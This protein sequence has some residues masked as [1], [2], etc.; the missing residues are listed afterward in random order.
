MYK[1]LREHRLYS[2]HSLK[3]LGW[4]VEYSDKKCYS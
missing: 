2:E 4:G 1:I 3:I